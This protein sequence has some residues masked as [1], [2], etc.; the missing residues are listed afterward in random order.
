MRAHLSNSTVMSV[1]R[2]VHRRNHGHGE[3]EEID[4]ESI[5]R[6]FHNLHGKL[7]T[8]STSM[9]RLDKV[10]AERHTQT[11]RELVKQP[12][13]KLCADCKRNGSCSA[14]SLSSFFH[15]DGDRSAVGVMEFVSLTGG[16]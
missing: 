8:T 9:S 6:S 13:N 15:V 2:A 14:S 3:V 12:E 16:L 4:P 10:T 5:S 7:A 1:C 11:L